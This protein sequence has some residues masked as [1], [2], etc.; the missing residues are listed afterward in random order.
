M[1][2]K[3]Q[4]TDVPAKISCAQSAA[5]R[6]VDAHLELSTSPFYL[7][8]TV[9]L[10][11]VEWVREGRANRLVVKVEKEVDKASTEVGELEMAKLSAIVKIDRDDFWMT[12]DAGYQRPSV[13][14][15]SLAEVKLSCAMTMPDA[16]PAKMDYSRVVS[17]LQE[18]QG[19]IATPGYQMGKGFFLSARGDVQRFKLRHVLFE[20][21]F[22]AISIQG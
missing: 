17:N 20:V 5:A 8:Q 18:L 2:D 21:S 16:Q 9:V 19:R 15:K 12:S 11:H 3:F 10:D 22:W 13:V 4:A 14:W 7:G 6:L 1:S